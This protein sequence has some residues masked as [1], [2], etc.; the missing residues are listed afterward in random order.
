VLDS[1]ETANA[2]LTCEKKLVVVSGT[3]QLLDDQVVLE[4]VGALIRD[5]FRHHLTPS[6]AGASK[7]GAGLHAP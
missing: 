7:Q 5:W 6:P 4:K 1:N 3:T 2:L